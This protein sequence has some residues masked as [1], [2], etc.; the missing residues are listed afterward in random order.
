[1]SPVDH[2]VVEIRVSGTVGRLVA[3][4][5]PGFVVTSAASVT[6]IN[7]HL[8]PGQDLT[9][10]LAVLIRHH[11]RALDSRVYPAGRPPTPRTAR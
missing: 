3:D 6:V 10:I 1:M 5:L 2:R 11:V 4:H 9:T 7:G 8:H